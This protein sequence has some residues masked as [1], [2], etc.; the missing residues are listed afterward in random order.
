MAE[1]DVSGAMR[2][3]QLAFFFGLVREHRAH[4]I[5]QPS[6]GCPLSAWQKRP[7]AEIWFQRHLNSIF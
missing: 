2:P 5:H 7:G 3:Q 1:V 6:A 4:S